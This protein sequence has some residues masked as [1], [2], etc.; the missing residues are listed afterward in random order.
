MGIILLLFFCF[1]CGSAK[2]TLKIGY[3]PTWYPKDFQKMQPNVNAYI[4]ELL[5]QISAIMDV[6][7]QKEEIGESSLFYALKQKNVDAVLSSKNP[8]IFDEKVYAFS[9]IIL[10]TGPVLIIGENTPF[11]S[12]DKFRGKIGVIAGEDTQLILEKYPDILIQTYSQLPDLCNA[13][14]E[15]NIQ[16][17]LIYHIMAESYVQNNYYDRLKISKPLVDEGLRM[18][19]LYNEGQDLVAQFNRA[20]QKLI[21]DKAVK[22]LLKKWKLYQ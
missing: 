6:N 17:G 13:I 8:Y 15:E 22:Q 3:D 5:L 20:Y 10:N 7:F 2:K 18:I 1:S 4:D 11:F 21:K 16:G 12:L 14:E 19:A 9:D